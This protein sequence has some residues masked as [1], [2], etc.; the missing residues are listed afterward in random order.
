[1]SYETEHIFQ[2]KKYKWLVKFFD[3]FNI[4]KI[5]I[6]IVGWWGS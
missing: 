2:K 6:K 3:M 5:Q 1:M 4:R